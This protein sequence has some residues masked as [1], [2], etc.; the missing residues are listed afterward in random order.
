MAAPTVRRRTVRR[1][2]LACA[3]VGTAT[4]ATTG[5]AGAAGDGAAGR[6]P[7]ATPIKHLVVLFQENVPF[8]HYFGTY[9][10]ATNPPGEPAFRPKPG[11]PT[12]N[13]LTPTLLEH[14]PNSANPKR[15]PRNEPVVCGSNHDYLAEQK[16]F[17]HGLMDR[18]VQE[19]GSRAPGCDPSHVMDYYDGN[20]VTGL[21][22]YAQGFALNDNSFGTTF[23]PSHIGAL[24]LVSGQTHGAVPSQPT[25]RIVDGT[26]V[27]NVEPT[28]DDCPK[29]ALNAHMTGRNV[30][31]LLNDGGVSW[32]WF[33]GGFRATDRTADGSA[34][35]GESHSTV[36]G[37][38][39]TD[40]DSGN[41][42]FQYYAS[43]ANAHHL[44]P[45][46]VAEVGHDGRANHQY[47]L[48]D[49][50]AA[51]DAGN[52][53]A[54]SFLKA[55]GYEQGGCGCSSPLDEQNFVVSTINHLQQLPSWKSTAV[56]V[57]YDDSDGGYDHV[58]GPILNDSQTAFDALTAPGKCGTATPALGGYQGRCGYG[59]RLPLL[60]VSPY[61]KVNAVDH[62]LTDQ[63][64]IIRFV[65]DNWLGGRRIGDGSYD[66]LAGS[67]TGM[68]DFTR[69]HRAPELLLNPATG[70]PTGGHGRA[71]PR[72]VEVT[73][74]AT[75][76]LLTGGRPNAVGVEVANRT[77]KPSQFTASVTAPAGWAVQGSTRKVAAFSSATLPVTVTPP[78][79]PTQATFRAVVRAPGREVYGQESADVVTAPPGDA[80]ALGLD[81]GPAAAPVLA[82]YQPLTPAQSFEPSRG[83]GWV[84]TPPDSRDRAKL[85][86]LR[87]DFALSRSATTLR[88][89]VP[90]GGHDVSLLRGDAGFPSAPTVVSQ[91][92]GVVSGPGPT[93]AAG[94]F[95]WQTWHVDGGSSGRQVDLTLTGVGGD[96]WRVNGL[97]VS[98]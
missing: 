71:A 10:R 50:D 30:G 83:Y 52:L 76:G 89:A 8:D 41:E 63:T 22:N 49:F 98:K 72:F 80:V 74:L 65:E 6:A 69:R 26:M 4:L 42:A 47:D 66:A 95:A 68:L 92:G 7:T 57:A 20:T 37:Q 88:L 45:A 81:A 90:A 38:K 35:C 64:S 86:D 2:L 93:L 75:S 33:S 36:F 18:F 87:R 53:P 56:V 97:V 24:N 5:T 94:Q 61:S 19:T 78:R 40:Y 91:D 31:D 79:T 15:L 46:S 59:P 82:G 67:L 11:T 34:V 54:V 73:G 9:P 21:W 96:Y 13:G 3:L 29:S 58:A 12:V 60:V 25:S 55:G 77:A 17:D 44:P 70:E 23:G 32:G 39:G 27:G 14:N 84:G 51:A 85:D 16:A 43:T 48:A 28:Y 62:S 1:S